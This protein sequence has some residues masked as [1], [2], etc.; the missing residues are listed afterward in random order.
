[1]EAGG[2]NVLTP[3]VCESLLLPSS[4]LVYYV[5]RI[6]SAGESLPA[7]DSFT[8]PDK[9]QLKRRPEAGSGEVWLAFF[10]L[11]PH[12]KSKAW[13][14][15]GGLPVLQRL[16][17]KLGF[18]GVWVDLQEWDELS[19]RQKCLHVQTVAASHGAQF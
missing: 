18:T 10:C 2:C 19:P 12:R 11:H 3:Q 17:A 1:M 13:S 9:Y 14:R 16:L 7:G 5:L 8:A 15:T 6:S 4:G